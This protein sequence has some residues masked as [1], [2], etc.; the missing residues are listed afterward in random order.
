MQDNIF[1]P[2]TVINRILRLGQDL[3]TDATAIPNW[4]V[5]VKMPYK[6]YEISLSIDSSLGDNDLRRGDFRVYHDDLDITK[7]FLIG[8]QHTLYGEMETLF[9]ICGQIDAR[10]DI[11]ANIRVLGQSVRCT[12]CGS[13]EECGC[14]D[15]LQ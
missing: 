7:E 5:C 4:C 6:G 3:K 12:N 8:D 11:A 1:V 13:T 14:I 10:I 15:S 2:K 9:S